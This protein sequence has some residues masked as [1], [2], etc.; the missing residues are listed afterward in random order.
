MCIRD[1][2]DSIDMDPEKV[3]EAITEKTKAILTIDLAAV[4]YTHLFRQT[5]KGVFNHNQFFMA[6]PAR[7]IEGQLQEL[8]AWMES[9]REKIHPLILSS[10]FHYEVLCLHP[11]TD[12]NSRLA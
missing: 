10:I 7:F 9:Q 1:R 5:E 6:P 8:F 12:G 2:P 11:F 4:S 3:R